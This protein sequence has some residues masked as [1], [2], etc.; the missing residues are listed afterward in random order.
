MSFYH[1]DIYGNK[2][3]IHGNYADKAEADKAV[4]A[5]ILTRYENG[6]FLENR[7][8]GEHFWADGTFR[9]KK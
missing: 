6:K 8:T 7:E 5:G 4:A 2:R 3:D 9:Y 1:N